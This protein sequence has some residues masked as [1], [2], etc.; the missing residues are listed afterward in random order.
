MTVRLRP[1]ATE[2]AVVALLGAA[3]AAVALILPAVEYGQAPRVAQGGLVALGA[4]GLI[5]A[6]IARAVVRLHRRWKQKIGRF[7]AAAALC[8][9]AAILGTI[10]ATI[11]DQC[12]GRLFAPGRCGLKEAAAWGQAAGL[13]TVVNFMLAGFVLGTFRTARIVIRDGSAQCADW[14]KALG[15]ALPH[16]SSMRRH[17][18]RE[19]VATR[20]RGSQDS[21]GRP[22]PRRA[23]AERARRRR[24]RARA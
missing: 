9:L 24:L 20:R 6:A 8:A 17:R 11:P 19:P 18:T 13:A 1:V 10:A 22:T 16:R 23:D 12:P 14:L 4:A 15:G 2:A 7:T 21:K 3:L 5:A